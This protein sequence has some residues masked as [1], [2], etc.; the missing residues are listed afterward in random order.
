MERALKHQLSLLW[1]VV[2]K[3]TQA[4]DEFPLGSAEKSLFFSLIETVS[5]NQ[6]NFNSDLSS[7]NI[8]NALAKLWIML[9]VTV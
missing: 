6:I 8:H 2:L 3:Y 5:E 9:K 7:K 1:V 4:S